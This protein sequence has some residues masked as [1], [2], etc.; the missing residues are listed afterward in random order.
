MSI[1]EGYAAARSAGL[2]VLA[3]V[4]AACGGNLDR[5]RQCL[6]MTGYVNCTDAF[7]D[8]PKVVN[9]ASDLF[10]DVFGEVGESGACRRGREYAA[11]QCRGRDRNGVGVGDMMRALV[12]IGFAAL[13]SGCTP[14]NAAPE[15]RN[16]DE[17]ARL[18]PYTHS[19]SAGGLVFVC[20]ARLRMTL[21]TGLRRQTLKLKRIRPLPICKPR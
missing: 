16:S 19:V 18:G 14:E 1:E 4:R 2:N 3:Q 21:R 20:R 9:G 12:L 10:V 11:L 17:I 8:Q 5:V 13:L 6:S 7:T 15:H